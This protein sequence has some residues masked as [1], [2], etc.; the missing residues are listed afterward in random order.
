VIALRDKGMVHLRVDDGDKR[1]K[2]VEP[3]PAAREYIERLNGSVGR[4]LD[5]EQEA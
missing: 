4:L 3:A 2:F 1:V 5:D